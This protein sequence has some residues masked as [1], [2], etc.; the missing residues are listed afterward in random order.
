M[1]NA[2]STSPKKPAP[3]SGAKG[4]ICGIALS[5]S[6]EVSPGSLC[7]LW[8]LGRRC[9]YYLAELDTTGAYPPAPSDV[10]RRETLRSFRGASQLTGDY[11]AD[12]ISAAVMGY[13]AATTAGAV[14]GRDRLLRVVTADQNSPSKENRQPRPSLVTSSMAASKRQGFV[15][16]LPPHLREHPQELFWWAYLFRKRYLHGR[17]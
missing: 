8:L 14:F 15:R 2:I 6:N 10:V 7:Y 13:L 9:D 11:G 12:S 4:H 16:S 17:G 1:V 5:D 3:L